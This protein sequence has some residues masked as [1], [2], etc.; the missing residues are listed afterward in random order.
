MGLMV[1]LDDLNDAI[2][3][4]PIL[5]TVSVP[6]IWSVNKTH[7]LKTLFVLSPFTADF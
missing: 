4:T 5:T 7:I 1:G 3:L 6:F 2:I